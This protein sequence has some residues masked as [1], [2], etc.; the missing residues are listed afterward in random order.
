LLAVTAV[1]FGG[2]YATFAEEPNFPKFFA[3]FLARFQDDQGHHQGENLIVVRQEDDSVAVDGQFLSRLFD[4]PLGDA[5]PIK[6][7]PS[8]KKAELDAARDR[9]ELA[10]AQDVTQFRHPNDL[11]ILAVAELGAVTN[12]LQETS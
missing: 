10:M 6:R 11:V 4:A 3:V 5:D 8:T 1:D 12:S 7:E 2:S 9:A